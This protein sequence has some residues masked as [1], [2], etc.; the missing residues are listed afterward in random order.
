MHI[1]SNRTVLHSDLATIKQP[2]T[3]RILIDAYKAWIGFYIP[4]QW[5]GGHYVWINEHYTGEDGNHYY[6]GS[7]HS[8]TKV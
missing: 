1:F 5:T 3:D 6:C 7:V 4:A 2:D 8:S